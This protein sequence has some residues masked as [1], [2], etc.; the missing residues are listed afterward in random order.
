M[1]PL[2][3]PTGSGYPAGAPIQASAGIGLRFPHHAAMLAERPPV[4]WLEVH[5]ENYMGGGAALAYLTAIRQHYPL[6]LHAVGLSLG[7]ADGLDRR[8][9]ER[10]ATLVDRIEPGLVSE[11]LAWSITGGH[12]VA[13]LLPLPLTE[14]AL[15]VVCRN[16]DVMQTRLGRTILVENPSTCLR[17]RHSTIPEWEFLTAV[18]ARTGCGLL[19]D[20]NNIAVSAANHG[21]DPLQYLHGLP[22]AC[23]GEIHVAGHSVHTLPGGRTIRIDDHGS[24]V[25]DAVWGL[26]AAA[27]ARFGAVPTLVEW[28]N[29]IPPLPVLLA[30]ADAAQQVL[31]RATG[32]RHALAA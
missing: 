5:A 26:L 11:H 14:E 4:A 8:H 30:E 15:D 17:F 16:V 2:G 18:A 25:S 3:V 13:D 31:D 6:S 19:C 23:V 28:D 12:Y 32:V 21:F 1:S 27:T 20:V 24:R 22:P 29:D 9:L 7:S 10:L